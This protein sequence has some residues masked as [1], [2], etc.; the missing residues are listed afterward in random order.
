[1]L[2]PLQLVPLR[3]NL[4]VT[5]SSDAWFGAKDAPQQHLA[6][7]VFR[8]I[9]MRLDTV[10]ATTNGISVI[11][12]ASSR[13]TVQ[14]R[15]VDPERLAGVKAFGLTGTVA[16]LDGPRSFYARFGDVFAWLNLLLAAGMLMAPFAR[17]VTQRFDSARR[18]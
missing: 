13:V 6:L 16:L 9:E 2:L 7:A 11:I 12:D 1:M 5:L 15:A 3:L 14:T 17:R 8:S 10:P 4:L 18:R